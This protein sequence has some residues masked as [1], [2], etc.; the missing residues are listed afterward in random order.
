MQIETHQSDQKVKI[1]NKDREKRHTFI[2]IT[3][4][5]F[6]NGQINHQETRQK[7]TTSHS[8]KLAKTAVHQELFLIPLTI[9]PDF[10]D[11]HHHKFICNS[12]Y[13]HVGGTVHHTMLMSVRLLSAAP[14][15]SSVTCSKSAHIEKCAK[16]TQSVSEWQRKGWQK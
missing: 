5:S 16:D 6:Q 13:V 12:V 2:P 8:T 7:Q 10:T 1:T 14:C 15:D 11:S 3:K 4:Y 9:H